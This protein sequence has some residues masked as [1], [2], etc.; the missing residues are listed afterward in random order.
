MNEKPQSYSVNRDAWSNGQIESK[1]WL[2]RELEK[3][4]TR[5][6]TVFTLGGWY[7]LLSFLLLSR[8]RMAINKIRNIDSDSIACEISD[9]INE[10][11]VID[12]WKF[13]SFNFNAN[14][15]AF[16]QIYSEHA[17]EMVIINTSCEHFRSD[18]W[19]THIP[20]DTIVALQSNNLEHDDATPINN[21]ESFIKKYPLKL[22]FSGEKEFKY[23][24]KSFTRFMTIGLKW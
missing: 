24:D 7:G 20:S 17:N 11:W 5:R 16:K 9:M 21:L 2:C 10:N 12:A 6:V 3:I 22:I 4:V 1:L 18:D 19:F 8:E 13:K 14:S 15:I 23:P